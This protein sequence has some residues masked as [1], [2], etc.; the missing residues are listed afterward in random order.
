MPI[1]CVWFQFFPE[2]KIA[3]DV[4]FIAFVWLNQDCGKETIQEYK[5]LI[6]YKNKLPLNLN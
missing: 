1:E 3:Q 5:F 2:K 4:M 6:V